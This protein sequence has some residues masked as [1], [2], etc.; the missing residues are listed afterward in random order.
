LA[1]TTAKESPKA[2]DSES[3]QSLVKDNGQ[4]FD[5]SLNEPDGNALLD[6]YL[7]LQNSPS[8]AVEPEGVPIFRFAPFKEDYTRTDEFQNFAYER[9]F[10]SSA[11]LTDSWLNRLTDDQVPTRFSETD[12]SAKQRIGHSK[13]S[14]RNAV[15]KLPILRRSH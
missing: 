3:A 4:N 15:E 6:A 8:H 13:G 12:P 9:P 7:D 5:D 10:V 11:S 14:H 1:Q 2:A